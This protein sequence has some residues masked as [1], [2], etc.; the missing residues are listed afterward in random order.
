MKLTNRQIY[1]YASTLIEAFKD[2]NQKLPIKINFYLQKNKTVLFELAQDI[3]R[4]RDNL[5]KEY[6]ELTE[7]GSRYRIFPDKM[8]LVQ[9]E[10]EDLLNLPQEVNIQTVNIDSLNDELMLTTAQMEALMFMIE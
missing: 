1:D 4:A 6:G 7:D 3:E 2:G 8:D 5:V 9:T 10:L